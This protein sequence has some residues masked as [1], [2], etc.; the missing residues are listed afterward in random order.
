[1]RRCFSLFPL[2]KSGT[3][4]GRVKGGWNTPGSCR[5]NEAVSSAPLGVARRVFS[6]PL[7][8]RS[9]CSEVP[10]PSWAQLRSGALDLWWRDG[11]GHVPFHHRDLRGLL[12]LGQ[13]AGGGRVVQ[14]DLGQL[15][16]LVSRRPMDWWG[17]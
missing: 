4:H 13:Q 8:L 12:G 6:L 17:E 1:M 7:R 2:R 14:V 10:E 11:G 3:A 9:P 16:V 5:W 15:L